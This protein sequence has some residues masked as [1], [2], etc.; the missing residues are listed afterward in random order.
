[1]YTGM[2]TSPLS[3]SP[4]TVR[5]DLPNFPGLNEIEAVTIFFPLIFPNIALWIFPNH[6]VTLLY[7]PIDEKAT[8]ETMDILIHPSAKSIS[9]VDQRLDRITDFWDMVNKQD[10]QIVESVQRGLSN[11]AYPGGRMCYQFEEPVH[12]FQNMVID[13]LLGIER[14][15]PGDEVPEVLGSNRE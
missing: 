2:C 14:I 1:M 9:N 10:I 8:L 13:R 3:E 11:P 15:P 7:Q 5:L 6:L 4:D 12:R